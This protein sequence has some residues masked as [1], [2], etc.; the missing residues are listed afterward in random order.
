MNAKFQ[1]VDR[2]RA[3]A[4][5][6]RC[7]K[8][9]SILVGLLWCIAL[10]AVIVVGVLRRSRLDLLT[11]KNH[12]DRIQAHY[13]ALAGIERAKALLYHDASDRRRSA[14]NHS[15]SLY[16]SSQDFRE[17]SLGRGQFSVFRQGR[18]DEASG[19][20]Y[21]LAD[22]ESRLNVNTASAGELGKL[23]Q[24]T[25]EVTAALID[26]RDGDSTVTQGGA[27]AESYAALQP[28]YLPRDGPFETVRELLMVLG[29]P[30]ELFL[31]EDTNQNGLLD[32]EEDDGNDF[33]PPDN[34][35]GVLDS[36]W[37]GLMTVNS[38]VENID[39]AG[40]PRLNIASA[41]ESSLAAVPGMPADVAKAIVGYRGENELE[42][43]ADLLEVRAVTSNMGRPPQQNRSR[44]RPGGFTSGGRTF[45]QSGPRTV[46]RGGPTQPA[47]S[48]RAT[49]PELV[50]EDLLMEIA[51]QLTGESNE[52][53][54]G[55][56][57]I[58]TANFEVLACLPGIS[59]EIAQAIISYRQS[60]GFFPNVA[61]LLRVPGMNRQIF[62]EALPRLCVRSE[63]FRI[64]SEGKI[65]STGARKRIEEIVRVGRYSVDTLSY[66][67]DL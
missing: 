58:N 25:P 32:P 17:V 34:H 39:A 10:L 15:G 21:G 28:P 23:Y 1:S 22:E 33:F 8:R 44:A 55:L 45:T 30:R 2:R 11:V 65:L 60:A 66:R 31:G 29:L 14:N 3:H 67:E 7:Q 50:S 4:P 19:I 37:S 38:G 13:L 9:A 63:T 42:N 43:L 27:E 52:N 56:I 51:D 41:D 62:R 49:G 20:I 5:S 18:K 35:D 6:N 46:T 16:N 54:V 12:G 57:N 53:G 40:E 61:W 47:Q 59:R 36:G 64:L 48:S 26:Y 24:M